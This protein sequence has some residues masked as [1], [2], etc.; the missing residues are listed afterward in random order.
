MW[1]V[2]FTAVI[3]LQFKRSHAKT[4]RRKKNARSAIS[5]SVTNLAHPNPL[6]NS[7]DSFSLSA[8]FILQ[9]CNFACSCVCVSTWWVEW[10]GVWLYSEFCKCGSSSQ[11]VTS[12][13][14]LS[15]M[16]KQCN[17][18]L[19]TGKTFCFLLALSSYVTWNLCEFICL[20]V[21][22]TLCFQFG[23]VNWF[24]RMLV[25]V[26]SAKNYQ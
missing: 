4:K 20:S 11:V 14:P 25:R 15:I 23:C 6:V 2:E 13:E 16:L 26:R 1:N 24:G 10:R 7:R 5:I 17:L 22:E 18:H 19:L 3:P 12:L 9:S 8:I 21:F